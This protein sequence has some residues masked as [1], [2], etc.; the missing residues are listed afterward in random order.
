MCVH[1]LKLSVTV[2]PKNFNAIIS[3]ISFSIISSRKKYPPMQSTALNTPLDKSFN[4]LK[5]YSTLNEEGGPV[6]Q[7]HRYGE[8]FQ[9]ERITVI[10][11]YINLFLE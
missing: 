7:G 5:R 8:I 2:Y 11:N 9:H 1:L 6:D 3:V 10:C 4:S